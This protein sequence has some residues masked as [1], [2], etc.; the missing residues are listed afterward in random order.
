M[1]G[2]DLSSWKEIADYFGVSVRTVQHW[3]EERGLPVRRLPG[4]GR[5]RVFGRISELEE[6]K[7]S[8]VLPPG[9]AAGGPGDEPSAQGDE[10]QSSGVPQPPG[11][12][13]AIK[14]S[15]TARS[16]LINA[17]RIAL[18]LAVAVPASFLYFRRGKPTQWRV[19]QATLIA[20]DARSH[21]LW[22][23]V[24]DRPLEPAAYEQSANNG[25]LP[26]FSDLDDDG[27][28]ELLFPCRP[29]DRGTDGALIC[30]SS[31]G[32]EKW[33]F[34]AGG[35]VR[36]QGGEAF[37]PIFDVRNFAVMVNGADHQKSLLVV[38]THSLYYPTQVALLS[39]NGTV[40]RQYWHSGHIGGQKQTLRVI[41]FNGDGREEVYL[42]GVT[43]G[44]RQATLVVLDPEGFEGAASDVRG[45]QLQGFPPGKEMARIL[46]PRGCMNRVSH[47]YNNALAMDFTDRSLIVHVSEL[48]GAT[49]R[50][51]VHVFFSLG[52]DLSL[53]GFGV[54]DRFEALHE[55]FRQQGKLDHAFAPAELDTFHNLK[56]LTRP[57]PPIPNSTARDAN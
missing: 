52:P 45:V 5:G 29:I 47:E 23:Q 27:D 36:S 24:F 39:G 16:I 31:K 44:Y 1:E 28:P 21:E 53:R 43:N 50:L 8:C 37:D 51:D 48:V 38:S 18:I 49:P 2:R 46:F 34:A 56:Y 10:T 7:R 3:E 26:R 9:D 6:W 55:E 14:T 15:F 13:A 11:P 32:K 54:G 57:P 35:A 4:G 17:L 12:A 40:L 19:E 41:D 33:R 20:L 30:Y 42:C 22:R 25:S